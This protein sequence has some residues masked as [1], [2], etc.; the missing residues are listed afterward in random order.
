VRTRNGKDLGAMSL[1]DIASKLAE[2]VAS[3][4][5]VTLEV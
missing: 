3:R 5:R 1:E 4:G 2:E